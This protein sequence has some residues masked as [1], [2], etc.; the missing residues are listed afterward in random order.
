MADAEKAPRRPG[1]WLVRVPGPDGGRPALQASLGIPTRCATWVTRLR[2][3]AGVAVYHSASYGNGYAVVVF[4]RTSR[5][6]CQSTSTISGGVY[7]VPLCS[8]PDKTRWRGWHTPGLI[9]HE[10][11]RASWIYV[12]KLP[13]LNLFFLV[14]AIY[15]SA[16]S[17]NLSIGLRCTRYD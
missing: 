5:A 10:S 12:G 4:H 9:Q 16:N 7:A 11:C 15:R 1:P 17:W 8:L 6:P 14:A 3:R 13:D 2:L